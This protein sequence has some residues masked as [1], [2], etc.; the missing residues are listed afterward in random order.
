ME[1]ANFK[2]TD[3]NLEFYHFSSEKNIIRRWRFRS[4][5]IW[6]H[7]DWQTV[8]DL[9]VGPVASASRGQKFQVYLTS[10]QISED[11]NFHH[12]DENHK[13]RMLGR[14]IYWCIKKGLLLLLY[15]QCFWDTLKISTDF[16]IEILTIRSTLFILLRLVWVT[17]IQ[18]CVTHYVHRRVDKGSAARLMK[19]RR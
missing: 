18:L 6:C 17:D 7:V 14:N 15:F 1:A 13:S 10:C 8:T 11:L 2:C 5:R 19:P 4:S 12:C 9:S 3:Y 16:I